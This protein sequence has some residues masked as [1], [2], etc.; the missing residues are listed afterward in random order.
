MEGKFKR[1]LFRGNLRKFTELIETL[2]A[3]D[4]FN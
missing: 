2:S 3:G 4:T 1:Y